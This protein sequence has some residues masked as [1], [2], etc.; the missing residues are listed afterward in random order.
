MD[1]R[2]KIIKVLEENTRK[3]LCDLG[4]DKDF[5]NKIPKAQPIEKK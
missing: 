3:N 4:L 5:L 2:P 1:H